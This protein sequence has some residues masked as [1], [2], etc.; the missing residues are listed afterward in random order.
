MNLLQNSHDKETCA[1]S[2]RATQESR[3]SPGAFP[4]PALKQVDQQV[5]I[6]SNQSERHRR[7]MIRYH[8]ATSLNGVNGTIETTKNPNSYHQP[9]VRAHRPA[10][11][12]IGRTFAPRHCSRLPNG[13][14]RLPST[15]CNENFELSSPAPLS[16]P[17]FFHPTRG[18]FEDLTNVSSPTIA[19]EATTSTT[20]CKIPNSPI[21]EENKS[22]N[23]ASQTTS[24]GFELNVN[25]ACSPAGNRGKFQA[26]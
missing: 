20:T 10:S 9:H 14:T 23:R 5:P 25:V 16:A 26:I 24:S 21:V 19:I 12:D 17:P 18:F 11:L 8:R 13:R 4:P 7:G 1:R 15:N 22:R 6:S 2:L 3:P